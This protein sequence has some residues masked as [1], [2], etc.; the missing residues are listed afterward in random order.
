MFKGILYKYLFKAIL[1][2]LICLILYGVFAATALATILVLFVALRFTSLLVEALQ[3]PV[4]AEQWE[5][6]LGTLTS[7]YAMLT[8]ELRRGKAIALKLDPGLNARDLAQ[9]QVNAFWSAP[10]YSTLNEAVQ[11]LFT[12]PVQICFALLV[13]QTFIRKQWYWVYLAIGA[14]TLFEAVRVVSLNL[15]NG[16]L[17]DIVLGVF[18][19]AS[20]VTIFVLYRPEPPRDLS[21]ELTGPAPTPYRMKAAPS[22][23]EETIKALKE[24]D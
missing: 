14:H 19:I 20:V 1:I 2:A 5:K 24:K 18:A 15:M 3:K 6:M 11:Q 13:L 12:V 17:V 9:A 7:D 22:T 23:V 16:Y 21:T 4:T 10:W 8:P